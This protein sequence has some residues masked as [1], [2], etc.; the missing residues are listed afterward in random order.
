MN[1]ESLQAYSGLTLSAEVV[2]GETVMSSDALNE[3]LAGQP[4]CLNSFEN[5]E[6]PLVIS[7]QVVAMGEVIHYEG[8]LAFRI[9]RVMPVLTTSGHLA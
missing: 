1:F 4:V 3:F 7:G 9:T 8:A 6:L 2:L 5:D